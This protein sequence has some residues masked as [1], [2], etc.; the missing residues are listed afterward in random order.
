MYGSIPYDVPSGYDLEF[1]PD[2]PAGAVRG[3]PSRQRDFCSHCRPPKY[4]YVDQELRCRTC[5]VVFVWPAGLQRHWYEV[6][7]LSAAAGPPAGCPA[8]RRESREARAARR[9]LARAADG[10]RVGPEDAGALVEFAAAM[11]EH[12]RRL[13]SGDVDRGVAAA[14]KAVRLDPGAVTAFFWE[15]VCHDVAGRTGRAEDCYRRF[16]QAA[17]TR[18]ARRV[19]KLLGRAEVRLV[20]LGGRDS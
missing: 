11:A 2:L 15:A 14:R 8:C 6:L 13:G 16:A 5:G 7:G 19:R 18:K 4:F 17:R 12:A 10:V 3:D 1:R 9:R 20:E